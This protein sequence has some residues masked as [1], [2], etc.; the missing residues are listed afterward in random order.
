MQ[1]F[2]QGSGHYVGLR[3]IFEEAG[4]PVIDDASVSCQEV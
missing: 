4:K 2:R 1:V 3:A